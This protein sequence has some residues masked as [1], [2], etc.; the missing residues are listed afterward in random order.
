MENEIKE[1]DIDKRWQLKRSSIYNLRDKISK[2]KRKVRSDFYHQM[3][4]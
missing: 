4:K 2:L 3:I 1:Y